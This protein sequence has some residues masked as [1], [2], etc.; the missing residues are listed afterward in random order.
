MTAAEARALLP[1]GTAIL[2]VLAVLLSSLGGGGSW[3][4]PAPLPDASGERAW[5]ADNEPQPEAL[6]PAHLRAALSPGD[7]SSLRKTASATPS[8]LPPFVSARSPALLFP[9]RS[10]CRAV[11]GGSWR[12]PQLCGSRARSRGPPAA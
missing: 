12:K 2:L 6:L 9:S 10:A 5:L 3:S 1:R 7:H 4:L 11:G 8:E